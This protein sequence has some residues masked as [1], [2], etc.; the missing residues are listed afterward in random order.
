MFCLWG[1]LQHVFRDN[2]ALINKLGGMYKQSE[3][4]FV[5][6]YKSVNRY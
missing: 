6:F 3:Y 1:C 4:F 5:S 2:V